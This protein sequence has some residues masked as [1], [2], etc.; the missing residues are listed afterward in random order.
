MTTPCSVATGP[1]WFQDRTGSTVVHSSITFGLRLAA[2]LDCLSGLFVVRRV[3]LHLRRD[4]GGEV[5][6]WKVRHGPEIGCNDLGS[7]GVLFW[8]VHLLI[9]VLCL[10]VS[11]EG[12]HVIYKV[13]N[14]VT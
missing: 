6:D 3:R 7:H 11:F 1:R 9:S 14:E 8:H 2:V 10:Q 5:A 4:V 12:M 13:F